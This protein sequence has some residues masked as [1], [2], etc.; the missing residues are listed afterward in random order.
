MDPR[1]C[2]A[3]DPRREGGSAAEF[4]PGLGKRTEIDA[5]QDRGDE[6]AD[7]GH[8]RHDDHLEEDQEQGPPQRARRRW[9]PP[10]LVVS[11]GTRVVFESADGLGTGKSESNVFFNVPTERPTIFIEDE[12]VTEDAETSP[13]LNGVFATSNG[14]RVLVGE[15]NMEN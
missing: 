8:R 15:S 11:H 4:E 9:A 5:Q 7:A 14:G 6:R 2:P 13:P 10:P 1:A 12:E 3:G